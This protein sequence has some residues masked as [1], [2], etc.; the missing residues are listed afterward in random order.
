VS[1]VLHDIGLV[2][3]FDSH[4]VPLA[5]ASGHVACVFAAGAGWPVERRVRAAEVVVPQMWDKVDV[6]LDPEG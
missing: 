6:N 4:T 3:E 1:A 2:K 5:E